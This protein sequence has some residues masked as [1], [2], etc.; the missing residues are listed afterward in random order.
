MEAFILFQS[1]NLEF[2]EINPDTD[3]LDNYLSWLRNPYSNPYIQGTDSDFNLES[4]IQYIKSKN[5][6]KNCA[7][8]GIYMRGDLIHIGNIKFE[9]IQHEKGL[10][11]VGIL[12]GEPDYR[13]KGFG[14]EALS[15]AITFFSDA[16]KI[17]KI[18][19]GVDLKNLPAIAM[20]KSQ[21]FIYDPELSSFYRKNIMSKILKKDE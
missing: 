12:I 10:A 13:R 5:A 4:L 19:L 9:P 20:Y 16:F 6:D 18:Y 14:S 11:C 2:K 17:P 15:S 3:N 21:G 8:W 1:K 7:L